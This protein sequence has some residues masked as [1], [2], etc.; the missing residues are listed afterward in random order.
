LK[1]D[2]LVGITMILLGRGTVPAKELADRFEVSVR[3]IV[4][5]IEALSK[6]GIPVSSST[7]AAGGYSII[8]GYKLD[9]RLINTGD[10]ASI[11]TALK[12]FLSAYDGERYNDLLEKIGSI[13]PEEKN[14]TIFYDFGASG[15]NNEI[16]MKLKILEKAIHDKVAVRISYVNAQGGASGRLTEPLA[17]SYRWYAW[18]LLAYCTMRKDYRIFKLARMDELEPTKMPFSM[19]H[20]DPGVL[21]E[22][23][24]QGG[25]RRSLGITL[26]C[27]AGVKVQVHEYL[28][29]EIVETLENGDFIL[30]LWESE[31][32][33]MWFSLLMSFGD[34]VRVLEPRE[35]IDRLK[36]KSAE[37]QKLYGD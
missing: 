36:E 19:E 24:F 15:E 5:D 18:Y 11:V 28:G 14:Q 2:R 33:R 32:E 22:Q 7:G 35:V 20:G 16:Q 29:G 1:I 23:A 25:G 27:K 8:E 10:Q 30:R 13:A 4:R 31:D 26:L 6:A 17:L 37:I 9:A 3:T 12:G 34:A 21:L